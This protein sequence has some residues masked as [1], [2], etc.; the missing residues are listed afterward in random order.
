MR[1]QPSDFLARLP[2]PATDRWPEGV[3][4]IETFA[5]SGLELELYAPRGSDPQGPHSRDEIYIVIAG[6]AA[7]DI[8]GVEHACAIGDALFVP[9]RVRHHFVD[10]S[11]DFATWVV[12][13]GDA[14]P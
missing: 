8:D 6:S 1:L 2:L 13:W 11:D 9:A 4:F 5:R 14:K 7:L 12:F 3:R 10:I